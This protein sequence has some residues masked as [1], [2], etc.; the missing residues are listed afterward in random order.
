VSPDPSVADREA[1]DRILGRW[2]GVWRTPTEE[3]V[4]IAIHPIVRTELRK[5]LTSIPD[6]TVDYGEFIMWAIQQWRLDHLA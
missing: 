3:R 1:A 4:P 2:Q 5:L 6:E